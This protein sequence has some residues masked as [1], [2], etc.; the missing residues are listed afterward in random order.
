MARARGRDVVLELMNAVERLEA[1][2]AR[3]AEQMEEV[4]RLGLQTAATTVALAA[5]MRAFKQQF[6]GLKQQVDGLKQQ[7]DGLKHQVDGLKHQID[8]VQEQ[9]VGLDVRV[10]SL[11]EETLALSGA[12]V[13]S[14]ETSREI[15]QQMGRFARLLA[16]FAEGNTSRF[17]DIEQR[18]TRLER[19]AG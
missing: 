3:H 18:L 13:K 5:D 17:D 8:G 4:A 12:L 6:D 19:K 11:E 16:Q 14:A 1:T 2:T 10:G 9:V 15:Q 7:V